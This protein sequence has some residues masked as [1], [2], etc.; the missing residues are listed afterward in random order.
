MIQWVRDKYKNFGGARRTTQGPQ[1]RMKV[2]IISNILKA[3]DVFPVNLLMY[4]CY[5]TAPAIF[6]IF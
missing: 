4:A 2:Y 5:N 3:I 6:L 1:K